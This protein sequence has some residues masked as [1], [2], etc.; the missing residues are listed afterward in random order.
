M[1]YGFDYVYDENYAHRLVRAGDRH[2]QYDE[3]GNV[4]LEQDASAPKAQTSIT[5]YNA[6][7]GQKAR[8]TAASRTTETTSPT[9]K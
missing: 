8:R 4:V 6:N 9:T 1:N 2:Y 5:S 3:N 7:D